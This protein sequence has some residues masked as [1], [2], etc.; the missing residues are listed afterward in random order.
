[1]NR[2]IHTLRLIEIESAGIVFIN[3]DYIINVD[4]IIRASVNALCRDATGPISC[5]P[6]T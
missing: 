3:V 2:G 5:D 4:I 1:M 6:H